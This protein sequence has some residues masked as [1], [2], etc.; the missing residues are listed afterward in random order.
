MQNQIIKNLNVMINGAAVADDYVLKAGDII[1]GSEVLTT[2][3]FGP[4]YIMTNPHNAMLG[5]RTKSKHRM[6]LVSVNRPKKTD[7]EFVVAA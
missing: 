4:S 6:S 5:N 7:K 2:E 3:A 1:T